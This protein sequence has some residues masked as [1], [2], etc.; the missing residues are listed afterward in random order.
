MFAKD[1]TTAVITQSGSHAG[2]QEADAR[3]LQMSQQL[4]RI[5][6]E[7]GIVQNLTPSQIKKSEEFHLV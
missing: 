4:R 3:V 5:I 2:K 6:V 1:L 7:M